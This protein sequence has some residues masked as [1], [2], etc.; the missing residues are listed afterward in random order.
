MFNGLA[1]CFV[2]SVSN[3]FVLVAGCCPYLKSWLGGWLVAWWLGSWLLAGG[4]ALVS[5]LD[6]LN[7]VEK[8]PEG[9]RGG[10]R[11]RGSNDL[12]LTVGWVHTFSSGWFDQ[13]HFAGRKT[14]SGFL[15]QNFMSCS[16]VIIK[17]S[18]NI[19]V[20]KKYF[21]NFCYKIIIC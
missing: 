4:C 15:L 13:N 20:R 7:Q 21:E 17:A 16:A 5:S 2:G 11:G 14:M 12:V 3:G 6:Q 1:S 19:L 9:G 18:T 10:S 8:K